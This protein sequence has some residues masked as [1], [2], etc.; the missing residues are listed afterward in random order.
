MRQ[1]ETPLYQCEDTGE[2]VCL[3]ALGH[4]NIELLWR[5]RLIGG[6]DDSAAGHD[7]FDAVG[8]PTGYTRD[9]KERR[10]QLRWNIHHLIDKA[11]VE[12][13]IGAHGLFISGDLCKDLG[14]QTLDS[15][16]KLKFLQMAG[17]FRQRP[18]I[19]LE[20]HGTGI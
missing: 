18:G 15:L 4:G 9:G 5:D 20:H 1:R 3:L 16:Q 7:L 14:C 8:T 13:H 2:F 6:P 17:L 11:G 19:L 12:I 10:E